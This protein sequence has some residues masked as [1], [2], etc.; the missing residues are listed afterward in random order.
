MCVGR[1]LRA[2]SSGLENVCFVLTSPNW[3]LVL[4][5]SG[6]AERESRRATKGTDTV[7]VDGWFLLQ[8]S[9]SNIKQS[10]EAQQE[11]HSNGDNR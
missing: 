8:F 3:V 4:W 9:R 2:L 11:C 7:Y 1:R 5:D 10:Q 6:S